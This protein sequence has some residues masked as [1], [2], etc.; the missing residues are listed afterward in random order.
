MWKIA[1]SCV[2]IAALAAAS[3]AAAWGDLGHE[4]VAKIAYRHLTPAVK[5]KLDALL[6]SDS[7]TLTAPDIASRATWA[8]KY[9]N[10]H[11]ETAPWHFVEIEIDGPNLSSACFGFPALGP[12]Q[13]ASQGPSQD[14]IVDKITEFSAEL[15]SPSTPQSERLL[16]LKFVLHFVGDLHQP[17]HASDHHDE[18]GNCIGLNPQE[19]SA[20]NLHAFW[21]TPVVQALGPSADAIANRLDSQITASEAKAWSGGEPRDWAMEAFQVSR[22]DAYALPAR[23]TCDARGSVQLTS[24]Y[25]AMA[26]KDAVLQL[27]RAGIRLAFVLNQALR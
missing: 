21:D 2:L 18:G 5:S 14:C 12:G 25:K 13:S 19:S 1:R 11:R 8:D 15:K 4:V 3:P 6:A 17:L 7:D 9:R 27:Q 22:R 20:K 10:S 16:A 26:E 24:T 23:P